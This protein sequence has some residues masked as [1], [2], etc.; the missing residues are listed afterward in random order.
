MRMAV[1]K[2]THGSGAR[3][4]GDPTLS[5]LGGWSAFASAIVAL[6]YAVGFVLLK[7]AK[8]YSPALFAGGLL[9]AVVLVAVYER[10]KSN[11]SALVLVG[12]ILGFA[13]TLGATIHGAYDVANLLRVPAAVPDATLPF[14]VDPRGLLTFG[15]SGLGV[16]ALSR[17]A[18]RNAAL[19]RGVGWLGAVLGVLLIVIYLGRLIVFDAQSPLIVAPAGLGA[20]VSV[21]WYGLVGRELLRGEPLSGR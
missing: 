1:P 3:G 17:E 14:P 13:G 18:L 8:V 12:L 6:V 9:N 16:L 15:I 4:E 11:A 2:G 20:V 19:P 10:V 7:D 21:A 5:R